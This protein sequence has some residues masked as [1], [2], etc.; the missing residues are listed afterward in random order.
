MEN[1][2]EQCPRFEN[3]G[4]VLCPLDAERLQIVAW[5]PDDEICKK[6]PVP[7]W[8][9]MQRKVAKKA[10][11]IDRYFTYNMLKRN[12]KVAKG[13][14]GLDPNKDELPQLNRWFRMHPPKKELSK[15]EKKIIAKRFKEY[16][17]QNKK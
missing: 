11:D 10:K 5:Y 1:L 15:L 9:R 7:D 12:C 8:V 13:I 4:A 16:R 2:I 3:C 6:I 14:V 17:E